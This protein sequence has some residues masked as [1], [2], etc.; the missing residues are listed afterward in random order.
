MITIVGPD[1]PSKRALAAAVAGLPGNLRVSW[2]ASAPGA[3]NGGPRKNATEQLQAFKDARVACPEFTTDLRIA[4]QWVKEGHLVFGRR[5]E[6]T[7]GNDI[8][9]PRH[10]AWARR[11]FWVKVIRDVADEWRVHV[12]NGRSI[13]RGHKVQTSPPHRRMP[14]RNRKNGW[15]MEHKTDPPETVREAAKAAVKACGYDFGAVDLMVDQAGKVYVLEVN[16]A[17]GLDDYTASKYAEAIGKAARRA[18][19]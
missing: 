15:T 10:P 1:W 14:V 13:A 9:G 8:V 11:Q 4:K 5:L 18:A 2:G 6:H 19:A 12:F 16:R 17:P 3:V 7:Q